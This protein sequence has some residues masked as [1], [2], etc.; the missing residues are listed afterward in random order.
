MSLT[1]YI[2][3]LGQISR[4]RILM[5]VLFWTAVTGFFFFVF[6]SNNPSALRTLAVNVGFMPG[7]LIFAYTLMY[8]VIPRFLLKGK[9]VLSIGYMLLFLAVALLYERIADTYLVHYSYFNKIW[10]PKSFPRSIFA[11]FS[12]AWIAVS[13]K[14]VKYWYLEKE[15][16][17][18]LEKE[19]LTVELQ[20]LKSQLHPHF[21][22]NTLNNL[23]SLTLEGSVQAPQAV[24]QLSALLRY[25]LYECNEPLV[26]LRKEIE[27]LK[28]YIALEKFRWR[29]RVDI[30][31][32]FTGDIDD[33]SI[34]PLLLLPFVENA[35]KHGTKAELAQCWMSLHLHVEKDVLTFKV[36]NSTRAPIVGTSGGL[37]LQNV[38]RRLNLLYPG[39]QL[40]IIRDDH[41][42][43]V[44]LT[45]RV[46]GSKDKGSHDIS[47]SHYYESY[48]MEMPV[49][50]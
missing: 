50:R 44:S 43:S 27:V 5:H 7:H 14:L 41:A 34:A 39:H 35:I 49:S 37:G 47:R 29:D 48:E 31:T 15:I 26:D 2:R 22:F 23:Y 9:I 21:L 24:L 33:Q 30:S 36:V 18:R 12:V 6:R 20:L 8:W 28:T 38:Q 19:K 17:Q 45:I 32:S 25:M 40:K 13:I 11:L 1:M 16:Q 10:V 42:F 3:F 4:Q 46:T